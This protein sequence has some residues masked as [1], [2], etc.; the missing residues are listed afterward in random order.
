MLS[1]EGQD[2]FSYADTIADTETGTY[3][4]H[5]VRI[6]S[7]FSSYRLSDTAY[8]QR[9]GDIS[10]PIFPEKTSLTLEL[11]LV[12]STKSESIEIPYLASYLGSPFT[13]SES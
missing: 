6:N 10:G 2:P 5:G 13:D 7:V 3:L 8:S 12:N 4:D 9:L 1:I 11:L